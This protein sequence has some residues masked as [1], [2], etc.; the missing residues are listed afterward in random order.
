MVN[1]DQVVS[2]FL[3][4]LRP[5]MNEE[6]EWQDVNGDNFIDMTEMEQFFTAWGIADALKPHFKLWQ[7]IRYIF[8]TYDTNDDR[9]LSLSGNELFATQRDMLGYSR[10]F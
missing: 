7:L 8:N 3:G 6:F 9:L 2:M 1:L 4:Q 10:A 5:L